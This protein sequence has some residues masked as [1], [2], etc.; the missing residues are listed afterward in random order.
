MSSG[1]GEATL[2]TTVVSLDPIYAYFDADEQ[3]FLKLPRAAAQ[4]A[5]RRIG[6]NDP[7]SGWRS[8]TRGLPAPGAARLPRQPARSGRPARFAARRVSQ[9]R[10]RLTPGC[11]SA[12]VCRRQLSRLSLIRTAPSA[13]TSTRSSSTS[14]SADHEIEYRAGDARPDRRRP[15]RRAQRPAAG[16]RVVVN[17]LQRVRPGAQVD[18]GRRRWT[19]APARRR[20]RFN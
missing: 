2:L 5:Q 16:E 10:R 1:P 7:R 19:P 9:H 12:C 15:A 20:D 18:A 4:S 6:S 17:G 14:S 11:S 13:P 8:P 3:I